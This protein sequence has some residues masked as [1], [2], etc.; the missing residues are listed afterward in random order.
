[1]GWQPVTILR[2][3]FWIT[4][5]WST[6]CELVNP[7]M[8]IG[9]ML[10]FLQIARIS[11]PA[12]KRLKSLSAMQHQES[13]AAMTCGSRWRS[14]RKVEHCHCEPVPIRHLSTAIG[15]RSM[16]SLWPL[17]GAPRWWWWI[18]LHHHRECWFRM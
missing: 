14:P 1:M 3:L 5:S 11:T 2:S 7:A 13:H 8:S 4:S 18:S 9:M 12:T 6:W 15:W 17:Q 10:E 16:P